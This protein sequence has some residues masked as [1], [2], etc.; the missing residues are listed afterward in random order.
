ML[1]CNVIV[2]EEAPGRIEIAAIEPVASMMAVENPAL[3]DIAGLVRALLQG[4]IAD[5]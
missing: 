5:L 2:R 1:P 4:V 3:A